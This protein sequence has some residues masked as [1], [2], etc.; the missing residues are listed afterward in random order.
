MIL[1]TK[2]ICIAYRCPVCGTG[3]KSLVGIFSL[4][5]SIKRLKCEC[6]HSHLDI[7][8]IG[9]NR[10]CITIPCMFCRET[11]TFTVST[12]VFFNRKLVKFHC[13]STGME[14]MFIGGIDEVSEAL[15]K[16]EAEI[17]KILKEAGVDLHI[18][19]A[20]IF[21]S[22][23]NY[24]FEPIRPD[25]R[26]DED[27]E[28]GRRHDSDPVIYDA[29]MFQIKSLIEEGAV[30]CLCDLEDARAGHEHGDSCDHEHEHNCCDHEHADEHHCCD[31]DHTDEHTCRD[32]EH[33][34]GH[35]PSDE[36]VPVSHGDFA[37]AESDDHVKLFCRRCGASKD[38]PIDDP[39]FARRFLDMDH[40]TLERK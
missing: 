37:I 32:H 30:S 22:E 39:S 5:G 28:D 24:D 12:R 2:D 19:F 13:P 10:I 7:H 29:V 15:D 16:S 3:V 34:D 8:T 26:P 11:H 36:E 33:A 6:T 27:D 1:E 9:G 17:R 35:E 31:H 23:P 21:G 14:I 40:I 38:F 25:N 4:S 20:T 18:G